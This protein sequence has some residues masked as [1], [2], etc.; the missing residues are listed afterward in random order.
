MTQD[1]LPY[2]P[3]AEHASSRLADLITLAKPRLNGLVVLT[4]AAGYYMASTGSIDLVHLAIVCLGTALVAGGASAANQVMERD[5]DAM[6]LRTRQRPVAEGRVTVTEALIF[7]TVLTIAGLAMLWASAPAPAAWVALATWVSYVAIYTP[8]KRRTS[9]AT[10]IGAVPGA[11]PTLIG[12]AAVTGSVRGMEAWS[13]FFILF[14]WQLPH[15]IAIAWMYRDDYARAGM[16]MISVIDPTGALSGRQA[17]LWSASLIPFGLLPF[18]LG[19]TTWIYAVGA[20]AL[21]LALVGLSAAFAGHRS[22]AKA[23]TLFFA[24]IVYL[25]IL[26]G[27]MVLARR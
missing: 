8:L 27:L 13:L 19:M 7:S 12:W 4:T 2:A 24:S 21:G 9:F 18:V 22:I 15:F 14:Y 23:R 10:V 11:L 3:A 20:V 25:P 26:L 17:L 5:T 1:A 6:M 16:P